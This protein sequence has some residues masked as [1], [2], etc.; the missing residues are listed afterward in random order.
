MKPVIAPRKHAEQPATTSCF[1]A[2]GGAC[3]MGGDVPTCYD[4]GKE[5]VMME[6]TEQQVQAL[7]HAETTPIVAEGRVEDL[8][9]AVVG[10]ALF[11]TDMAWAED[12][13]VRL[14]KHQDRDVRG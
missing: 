10:V 11:E 9:R 13:C 4:A 2:P 8:V 3:P 14:A 6:L 7:D 1:E 5:A 12:F